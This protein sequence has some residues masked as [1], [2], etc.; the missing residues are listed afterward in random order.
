MASSMAP[1]FSFSLAYRWSWTDDMQ[2]NHL[3]ALDNEEVS[4]LIIHHGRALAMSIDKAEVERLRKRIEQ[5]E[6]LRASDHLRIR[7]V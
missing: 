5:L 1:L 3:L 2:T 4:A 7:V 6:D